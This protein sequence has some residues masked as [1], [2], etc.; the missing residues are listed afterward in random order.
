MNFS[1]CNPEDVAMIWC[2]SRIKTQGVSV[3]NVMT[4]SELKHVIIEEYFPHEE[5]NLILLLTWVV[6]I[7]SPPYVPE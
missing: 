5:M 3:A 1:T 6:L 2:T 7:I 4:W